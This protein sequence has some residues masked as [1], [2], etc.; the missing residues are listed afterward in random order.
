MLSSSPEHATRWGTSVQLTQRG[1]NAVAK[2]WGLGKLERAFTPQEH[3][4]TAYKKVSNIAIQ[5]T[6]M[7]T[8]HPGREEERHGVP[9][10][11]VY[12]STKR[13]GQNRLNGTDESAH[14]TG[15]KCRPVP[16]SQ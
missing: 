15:V 4:Q 14:L 8:S 2:F 6:F 7:L 5:Q 9:Q 1:V 11:K 12:F 10:K 3:I 16:R 13:Q